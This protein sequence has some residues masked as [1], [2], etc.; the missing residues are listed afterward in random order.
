VR[1]GWVATT[2]GE[3]C[4][5]ENGDRGKN[6]PGRKAMV[7]SGVPFINAGHIDDGNIS[8]DVMDY[9]PSAKFEIL[10]NGKIKRNDLLFCLR[11]SLGK[12]GV[13]DIET[14]GAIASSLV[15]VRPSE[16]LD[17]TYLTHYL[18]SSLCLDMID[19]FAGGA[20]QPNLAAKSL[21]AF[22]IPLPPLPEQQRIVA[23]LDE[24]FEGIDRAIANTEK[25]LANA[26]ELFN[27]YLNKV[28]TE[29]GEGWE[30]K[31]LEEIIADKQI[32]LV[33]NKKAQNLGG[34]VPYIKMHNIGND[35]RFNQSDIVSVDCTAK[36]I[37]KFE[38]RDGDLLFNTRN[39][40]ELVGKFCIYKAVSNRPV[41]YNNNIMRIRF[42]DT[43]SSTF[44]SYLFRSPAVAD[45]LEAMKSGTTNVSAIY[46][47][48]LGKLLLL[49]PEPS[50]QVEIANYMDQLSK[51][52]VN[53][54]SLKER[55]ISCLRE[56]KQSLLQKAFSG[57]LTASEA[58]S[59]TAEVA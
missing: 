21:K 41:V 36:E 54:I 57:E 24:A 56:L 27:S 13:V 55:Q 22:D 17:L 25:N 4:S 14:E 37:E 3:V 42:A 1:E 7:P 33:R 50:K 29:K 43:I 26:R 28:F 15:I 59:L 39:S 46:F 49:I 58:S 34:Q 32:G 8:W 44:V 52:Y 30:A 40:H 51:R 48:T 5:F 31:T 16:Q 6:Y 53:L 35:N 2:L 19:K 11:G 38:L 18:R 45:Q 23:I 20:A 9:I 47:K 12:F 10:G